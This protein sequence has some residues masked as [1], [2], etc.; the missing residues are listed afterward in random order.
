MMTG[1][2]VTALKMQ[3]ILEIKVY[4]KIKY[5]KNVFVFFIK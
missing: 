3:E 4:L 2:G 5:R 1:G